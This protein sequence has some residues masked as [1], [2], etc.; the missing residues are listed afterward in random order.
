MVLDLIRIVWKIAILVSGLYQC[1]ATGLLNST[2]ANLTQQY[3]AV[4]F[5]AVRELANYTT[6]GIDGQVYGPSWV[7]A[8]VRLQQYLAY[9]Q[10][11]AAELFTVT[12][13]TEFTVTTSN[14]YAPIASMIL[15]VSDRH[16]TVR[17]CPHPLL[18]VVYRQHRRR[19]LNRSRSW[20]PSWEVW[21]AV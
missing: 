18:R 9:G 19:R 6:S 11:A 3:I 8:P 5:N 1:M 2:I 4:Q 17:L 13:G 21:W 10:L 16:T 7:G 20:V 14:S 12:L 15:L